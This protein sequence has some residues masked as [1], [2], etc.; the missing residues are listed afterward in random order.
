MELGIPIASIH[1][2][3]SADISR[4][5]VVDGNLS[6][7]FIDYIIIWRK[8]KFRLCPV[9]RLVVLHPQNLRISIVWVCSIVGDLKK[10]LLADVL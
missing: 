1:I 9:L 2:K 4:R 10:L 5:R 6:R 3:D 8:E 7:K